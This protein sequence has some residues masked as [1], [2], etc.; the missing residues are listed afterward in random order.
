M[1]TF[2]EHIHRVT[3]TVPLLPSAGLVAEDDVLPLGAAVPNGNESV[4]F[5]HD[6]LLGADP[7]GNEA[8]DLVFN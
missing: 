1:S 8:Q 2:M 7:T 5:L 4:E 6:D 3:D